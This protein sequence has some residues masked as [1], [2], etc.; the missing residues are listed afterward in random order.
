[1][2]QLCCALDP[3]RLSTDISSDYCCSLW[4][5]LLWRFTKFSI[6]S[7]NIELRSFHTFL[8]NHRIVFG[9]LVEKL[10]C[11]ASFEEKSLEGQ[12][13]SIC[14][15]HP[16]LFRPWDHSAASISMTRSSSCPLAL[17]YPFHWNLQRM[18]CS[19]C[20]KALLPFR[21]LQEIS[22]DKI[23]WRQAFCH[24]RGSYYLQSTI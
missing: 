12:T 17:R 24:R 22:R 6:K 11:W 16:I 13:D 18:K 4:L 10:L 15:A 8:C 23:F 1:M 20:P 9:L 14:Q 21:F 7:R 3:N 19:S 2:W 5:R